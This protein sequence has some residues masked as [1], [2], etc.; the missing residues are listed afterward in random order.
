M[1]TELSPCPYCGHKRR[2]QIDIQWR[3]AHCDNC[4]ADGPEVEHSVDLAIAAAN[5]RFVCLDKN[6]DKVFVGDDFNFVSR[7][8]PPIK[9]HFVWDAAKL[10]YM[11]ANE[12]RD[13]WSPGPPDHIELIKEDKE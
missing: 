2:I 8:H 11:Y 10:R 9:L 1:S 3:Y 6:G 5:R 13:R 12:R 7:H 4:E